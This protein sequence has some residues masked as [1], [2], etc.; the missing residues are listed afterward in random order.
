MR[1]LSA[2]LLV[3]ALAGVAYSQTASKVAAKLERPAAERPHSA[4]AVHPAPFVSGIERVRIPVAAPPLKRGPS[5]DAVF[6]PVPRG[7]ID[8]PAAMKYRRF[9]IEL[10]AAKS[11]SCPAP[12]PEN[13]C[14]L[15]DPFLAKRR[16]AE[17]RITRTIRL[18]Y[19]SCVDAH[20]GLLAKFGARRTQSLTGQASSNHSRMIIVPEPITNSLLVI[21]TVTQIEDLQRAVNDV[22]QSV[23]V[24]EIEVYR[25][26]P[27]GKKTPVA[28]PRVAMARGREAHIEVVH[29]SGTIFKMSLQVA[30][31]KPAGFVKVLPHPPLTAVNDRCFD[32]RIGLIPPPAPG[33]F[34]ESGDCDK[35]RGG[36]VL[37]VGHSAVS[38]RTKDAD[39][40][41][42]LNR[43]RLQVRAYSV[44]DLLEQGA[45][46]DQ[47][48]AEALMTVIRMTV[49]RASWN[50]NGGYGTM[51]YFAPT[52]ALVIRHSADGHHRISE[53]LNQLRAIRN[54]N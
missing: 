7:L 37:T 39:D 47:P 40:P 44:K 24:F 26:G 9:L 51:G 4:S 50:E 2:M 54:S 46:N 27:D 45:H 18:K 42:A 5:V 41:T 31:V 33:V 15:A 22:E 30:P 3:P 20:R 35:D 1:I 38:K 19:I 43:L 29:D 17:P 14:P 53:L 52:H 11:R 10:H 21:G 48:C 34:E 12:C 49:D 25:I 16:A 32:G 23:D 8:A 6:Q 28:R 36:A 13:A